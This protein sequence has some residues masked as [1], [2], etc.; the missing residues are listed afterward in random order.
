MRKPSE[1][2]RQQF[3]VARQM[4]SRT[5]VHDV[6]GKIRQAIEQMHAYLLKIEK[7]IEQGDMHTFLNP[8]NERLVA[9][10]ELAALRELERQVDEWLEGTNSRE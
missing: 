7:A 10:N 1:D 4:Q 9:K 6:M 3:D 5:P 2:L 8:S